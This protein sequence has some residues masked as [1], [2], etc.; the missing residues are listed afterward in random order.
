[1]VYENQAGAFITD[2]VASAN[3]TGVRDSSVAWG[4]YDDDGD[5]DIL[6]TGLD[7]GY[8]PTSVVYENRAG[9]FVEDT[10]ASANLTGVYQSSAAWGDYDNDG[11]LDILLT[12]SDGG[13]GHAV[14]YENQAGAFVED[15]AASADL[16]GVSNSSAAWGDYDDDGDLDILLTGGDSGDSRHALVYRNHDCG[17]AL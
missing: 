8:V 1:V 13:D 11:D 17:L 2:T 7:S 16:V 6:L 3:L 4:D 12:G 10:V 14:V 5:L 15:S 9:V